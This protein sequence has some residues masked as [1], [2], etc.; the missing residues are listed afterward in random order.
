MFDFVI[1]G[2]GSAGCV[3]A[4]RLSAGGR[5]VALLEAGP[6]AQ[7]RF[8]VRAPGDLS[9]LWRT[10]LDW[11]FATTPQRH[12]DDREVYW[13]RGKLLGG[14]SCLNAMIYLRGHRANYDEWRELGNPGW[15]YADVL[16]YFKR[17]E[18]NPR[19]PSE[20]HGRG[21]PLSVEDG[22]ASRVARAFVEA[23]T[24]RSGVEI[25]P[26]FNGAEQAGAGLL[27][28][29]VRNGQRWDTATGFLDPV[30]GRANLTVITCS[31]V[32]GVVVDGD[33]VTGVRAR[34]G[35]T[36]R[37]IEGR[38]IILAAGTIGSPHLM[39]LS[40]IGEPD[41]LR[42]AGVEPRHA[43]PGVGKH[44]QD[45]PSL[46]LV[47][48][49]TADSGVRELSMPRFLGWSVEYLL[50]RGG[51]LRASVIEAGG[52]VRVRSDAALPDTALYCVPYGIPPPN[53][54]RDH[55]LFT[56]RHVAIRTNSFYP[57]S[58]GEIRLGSADPSAA[59]IIDPRY[60]S[61]PED[62]EHL[63]ATTRLVREIA[64]TAPLA[65]LLE[66][67][68]WPGPEHESAEALRAYVRRN[69][70]SGF[71][72]TGTCKMGVDP[73]AVVDPELC[74]RGLRGLRVA[75]ASIMPRL[76]GGNTNAPAIMIAEKAADLILER[77]CTAP[78]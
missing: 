61:A 47:F 12:A 57:R 55:G 63:V 8:K 29:T 14:T 78:A 5:T 22:P 28:Y 68:V 66:A 64:A 71:H 40:G 10:S 32:T 9:R 75:D 49:A 30:R 27:Q 69:V 72:P 26:D 46:Y 18:D 41:E 23:T 20:Y 33:R 44:L 13:P 42:A 16:P 35:S 39:M 54:D 15:G 51:P 60:L 59:P 19:G 7:H 74:V 65:G 34:F 53:L 56:G 6:P 50:G 43:L 67:E 11:A 1:V 21:G 4:N 37:M 52:L 48:A 77:D 2:A 24:V 73:E 3:L 31:L 45:H 17:S 58:V 70:G 25:N 36:E 76:I 62:L 38:E